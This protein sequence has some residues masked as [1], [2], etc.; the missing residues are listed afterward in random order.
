MELLGIPVALCLGGLGL[1]G[2]LGVGALV[3]VKLGVFA[4]YAL[5][6]E[7]PDLGDYDLDQSREAGQE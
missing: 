7:P 2:A 5:K 3:L 1:L 6:E 4:R